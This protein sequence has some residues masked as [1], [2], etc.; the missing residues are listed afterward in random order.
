MPDA[1]TLAAAIDGRQRLARR[2]A[3]VPG[4]HTIDTDIAMP[5][6]LLQHFIEVGQQR[7]ATT[8]GFLTQRQH[9]VELVLLDAFVAF[10]TLGIAEHLFEENHILQAVG[11]PGIGGQAIASGAS[12]FLVVRFQALGQIK[13]AD[14]THVRLVDAHAEGN[15]RHHDQ[16][17]LVEKAL[18][19]IGPQLVAQ[20]GVIGQ[21]RIALCR[22]KLGNFLDLLA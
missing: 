3:G 16:P 7:L 11:H 21:G 14:E 5:A 10:V 1:I 6:G 17:F 4:L 20:A 19:V 12:G 15:G 18:L 22:E 2:F 9:G 13:V 8:A